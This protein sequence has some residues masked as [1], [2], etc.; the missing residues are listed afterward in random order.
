MKEEY[1]IEVD[2]IRSKIRKDKKDF[3]HKKYGPKP[4]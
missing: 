1:P 3:L 4:Q 2:E